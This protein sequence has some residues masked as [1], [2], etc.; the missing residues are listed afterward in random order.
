[1][2]SKIFTILTLLALLSMIIASCAAPTPEVIQKEVTK[3]VPGTPIVQTEVQTQIVQ[4]TAPPPVPN[5]ACP[6]K[7]GKLV[8]GIDQPAQQMNPLTSS[9]MT[10]A[11]A[12]IYETLVT[13]DPKDGSYKDG[14]AQSWETTADG[15]T[16]TFHLRHGVTFSDGTSFNADAVKFFFDEA[17]KPTFLFGWFF[18]NLDN[19]EVKDEYTIVL[20]LKSPIP[21][22]LHSLSTIYAGIPSPTAVKKLGDRYG[23]DDVVGTGP[24]AL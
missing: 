5:K 7:G 1:M 11:T 22:L 20:H 19:A 17:K 18:T 15:L 6:V 23:V 12:A 8:W 10:E 2:K 13:R 14:L 21:D 16:W 9:W 4:V 3:I 24:F